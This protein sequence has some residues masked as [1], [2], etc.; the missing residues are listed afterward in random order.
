MMRFALAACAANLLLASVATADSVTGH[1][2]ETRNAAMWAGPCLYNSE[3]GVVG[4][5]AT[6]AWNVEQGHLDGVSL[7]ELSIVAVV[8]GDGT[9]GMGN[10]IETRT[11]LLIDDRASEAQE[12]ALIK[13][14]RALAS[15]TI[16]EVIA[17]RRTKIKMEVDGRSAY[18]LVDA[19]PVHI[20]TR[21]LRRSD[22]LCGTDV[23]R[24]VYPA[25][26]KISDE[27][28]AYTLEN[29]YAVSRLDMPTKRYADHN[30]PSAVV[31]KFSL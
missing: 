8:F 7:N 6:L 19:D 23:S 24:M 12:K 30:T 26:A 18:S 29:T 14:V 22:N 25:L 31:A 3:M 28:A 21:Q 27:R 20:R 5:T 16:Q 4:D 13:M 10:K 15:E 17:V 11:V 2:V 1:Y 9:F